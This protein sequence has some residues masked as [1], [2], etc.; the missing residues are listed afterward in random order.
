MDA[1]IDDPNVKFILTERSPKLFSRSIQ[2]TVGQV[3]RAGHS[4]PLVLFK[5]LDT[6]NWEF[7]SLVDDMYRVYTQG[8]W[9]KD[10]GS[11]QSIEQWYEQ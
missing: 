10:P 6:Y 8:K 9:P 4:F 1:Y 2:N 7:F 5:Y 3:V 11:D